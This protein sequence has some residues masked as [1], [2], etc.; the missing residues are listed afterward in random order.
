MLR[1]ESAQGLRESEPTL[2]EETSGD[3]AVQPSVLGFVNH[4]H[5]ATAEFLDDAVVGDG[6]SEEW[7]R[8]RHSTAMVDFG[9]RQVNKSARL[10]SQ[11]Q[12]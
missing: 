4:T 12:R 1:D 3:K 5:A 6:L 2:E 8:V 10:V 7:L 9:W 11:V